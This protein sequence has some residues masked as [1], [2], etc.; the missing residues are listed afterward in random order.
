M[1]AE[2]TVVVL[3]YDGIQ[4]LDLTGPVEVFDVANRYGIT[5]Q[6]R[7]EVVGPTAGPIVTSSGITITPSRGIND[8]RGA[9]D[10]IVVAGGFGVRQQVE[11]PEVGDAV[12]RIDKRS[13]RVASVCSGAFLL[14]EAGLLDHRRVTTHWD[15]CRRLASMYPLLD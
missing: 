1:P 3:A 15:S 11:N 14:A 10:T 9:V 6:Y 12:R 13:R 5:P 2:R 7:I 4:S 8:G